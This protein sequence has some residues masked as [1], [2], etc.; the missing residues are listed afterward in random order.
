M[1]THYDAASIAAHYG[2]T[3]PSGGRWQRQPT[4]VSR[5]HRLI[6]AVTATGIAP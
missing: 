1:A 4:F 3:R 2:V 5:A 6:T